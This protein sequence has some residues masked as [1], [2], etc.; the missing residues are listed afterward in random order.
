MKRLRRRFLS[1]TVLTFISLTVLCSL[2]VFFETVRE[3]N[4]DHLL[5]ASE[6]N[7]YFIRFPSPASHSAKGAEDAVIF[8]YLQ[9]VTHYQERGRGLKSFT[10]LIKSKE[11][12]NA[13]RYNNLTTEGKSFLDCNDVKS[14]KAGENIG[15]GYTKTVQKGILRGVEVALKSVHIDNEDIKRCVSNPSAPRSIEECFI[16]AK[17]KLAKEIIML[18]QLQ[19]ANIVKLLG[20]C[21]QNELNTDDLKSR[22][23]TM[24]TELGTELDVLTLVQL[25]WQERFRICLGLARLLH[26]LAHSP[27]GSLFIRDFKLSQF[28][29]V[30]GEVKLTDFD[31]VDN[32]EPRCLAD[33]DC[34][35]RGV[36]KNRTLKCDNGRCQGVVAATNLDNVCRNVIS[37]VLVPGAPKKL[38]DYLKEVKQN[39]RRLTLNTDTLVW[40]LERVLNL[41]RSGKHIEPYTR[42]LNLYKKIV[43]ADFPTLHDYH[44]SNTRLPGACELAVYNI[45][46]A[47]YECDMDDECMAFVTTKTKLWTGFFIVY[48]KS[49]TTHV[50][51]NEDTSVYIKQPT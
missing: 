19:H 25:P 8:T 35:V 15:R 37:H 13:Q 29:I 2:F 31:D 27:L 6:V 41:L 51:P 3:I 1:R 22:G 48:L 40:N 5:R 36:A 16:F 14:I 23:L 10:D 24:V 50:Q 30:R 18:Q 7:N 43:K 17:Y 32:E 20:F 45:A 11:N 38:R 34:V 9:P 28:I 21:W 49:N 42:P 46:E 26:Y 47:R 33:R 39:L 12:H 4:S 44:C